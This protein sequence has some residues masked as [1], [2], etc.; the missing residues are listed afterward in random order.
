MPHTRSAVRSG[1]TAGKI[2]IQMVAKTY[3]VVGND[4][5]KVDLPDLSDVIYFKQQKIFT[6]SQYVRSSDLRRAIKTGRLLLLQTV[7]DTDEGE[8]R[9][10]PPSSKEPSKMDLLL[11]KLSA[12]EQSI[13]SQP[14]TTDAKVVGVLSERIGKLEE[15][16]AKL[17]GAG[18]PQVT[19]A[20]RELAERIERGAKDSAI[21][22]R[23][24]SILGRSGQVQ[25]I[26][27]PTRPEDVYV[28]SV[29][30]EDG[31]SHIKLDVRT[32]EAT[33]D[34]LDAS[35]EALKKLKS[36]K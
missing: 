36:Q 9:S 1:R 2:D 25:D 19:E 31:K 5:Q 12:L 27:E 32:I 16:I 13:K 30:V 34:D 35:L 23:L 29:S 8:L 20:L 22:D 18:S 6:G 28:P 33:P 11:D 7:G 3:L 24:E 17:L 15:S 10:M 14:S 4:P 21:L 26:K